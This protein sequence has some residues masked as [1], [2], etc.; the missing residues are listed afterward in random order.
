MTAEITPM[1][2]WTINAD[3]TFDI[4]ITKYNNPTMILTTAYADQKQGEIWGYTSAG[5]I[6]DQVTADAIN[7]GSVQR[8]ISGQVWK[9]GDMSYADLNKDGKVDFGNNTVGNT[10]DRRIIG[11][12][13]PRYQYGVTLTAEW[14]GFDLS[15]FWQGV[16][17]RNLMLGDNFFWG[18]TGAV[19]SSIFKDHLNYFRD[20]DATKYAGLGKNTDAYFARPYLDG[21]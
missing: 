1:K 19:Q 2:G 13:T 16:G 10:G 14:K 7:S 20:A 4:T 3:Y 5:L 8:A 17:K 21:K 15:M 18:F 9:I 11:N 12:S 6:L